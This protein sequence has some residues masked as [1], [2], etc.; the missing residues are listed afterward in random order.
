MTKRVYLTLAVACLGAAAL[1]G[2]CSQDVAAIGLTMRAPQ[3]LLDDATAVDLE[4]MDASG[5]SCEPDGSI[6]GQRSDVQTFAMERSGCASGAIWCKQITLDQDDSTKIFA[7]TARE[8]QVVTGRGCAEAVIDQ[9]PVE[10]SITIQRYFPPKCCNDGELQ[11]GEQCDTGVQAT[12]DCAGNPGEPLC[13][14]IVAD[15]VCECDC[16]AREIL[17]S[18]DNLSPPALGNGSV[19][20]KAELALAFSGTAGERAGALRAVFT[21]FNSG[22]IEPDINLRMLQDDLY[23]FT[24]HP[25]SNQLRL[26]LCSD[27]ATQNSPPLTQHQPQIARISNSLLAVVYASDQAA[28]THHD[29]YLSAQGIFGCAEAAPLRVNYTQLDS[30]E[31]PDVAKA[32]DSHALVVWGDQGQLRGRIWGTDGTLTPVDADLTIASIEP[33][34]RPRVAG[35]SSGWVVAYSSQGN[36][37]TK[38]V[39]LTGN[40]AVDPVQVN[41]SAEGV[42]DQ[43]DVAML[44]DSSYI[45]VWHSAGRV[46]FQRY[47]GAGSAYQDDQVNPLSVNSPGASQPAV[48]GSA[49]TTS[50]GFYAVA[51]LAGDGSVWGRF[52]NAEEGFG[53]NSVTGQNDDFIASHPVVSGDAG[54]QRNQPAIAVGGA[55]FVA[56]GWQDRHPNHPGVYVRRFP[57]PE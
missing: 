15:D 3:G 9:D 28:T 50:A 51:W 11:V 32:D 14:G 21:D 12:T 27:P 6:T 40:I 31:H 57:L 44:P 48:A 33:G 1:A 41:T 45:V 17:L 35:S 23:P 39:T 25:L 16:T 55:G 52:V 7:V 46:F 34:Q 5:A 42:Q 30:C 20:D 29:I 8:G 10:V 36:V 22:T 53:Y 54:G 24:D 18:I 2:A 43:P 38:N 4:V 19:D 13:L 56:I 26:P 37:F 47:H 49:E